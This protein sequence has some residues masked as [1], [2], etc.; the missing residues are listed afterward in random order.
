MAKTTGPLGFL[1]KDDIDPHVIRCAY[2]HYISVEETVGC[3]TRSLDA[4][5]IGQKDQA[6]LISMCLKAMSELTDAK[7]EIAIQRNL[8]IEL[9]KNG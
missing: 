5:K 7:V 2:A 9:S 8:K 4:H 3:L 6:F 1:I